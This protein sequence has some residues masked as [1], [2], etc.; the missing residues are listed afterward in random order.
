[1]V[2]SIGADHVV[3]YTQEDFTRNGQKYDVI[4]DCVGSHSLSD[5]RRALTAE[6]TLVLVG[7]PDGG[8]WL[9]PLIDVLGVVIRSWFVKQK[10]LPFMAHLGRDDLTVM[11]EFLETGKVTPVIDR[12]Y[13]LNEVP[14][15]IRYLEVGHA[16]GKI[17][18]TVQS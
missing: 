1:M 14:E 6:G 9:G 15:A 13:P 7:G 8:R 10:L 5:T 3:D 2:R 17:V 12:S 16:R 4:L 11:Q 18:I